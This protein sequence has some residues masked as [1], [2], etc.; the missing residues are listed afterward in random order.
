MVEGR[1]EDYEVDPATFQA[2]VVA[3]ME[4]IIE[5]NPGRTV[6][7]VCHG[8]V[9]N[10]YIGH[11]LGIDRLLW[12]EPGYTSVSRVHAARTGERSLATLNEQAHLRDA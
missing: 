10:A 11:V 1:L 12:F 6:A 8:G 3:A 9:I 4:R 2:G 7:V 5:A